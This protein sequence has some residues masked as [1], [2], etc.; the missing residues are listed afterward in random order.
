MTDAPLDFG[1]LNPVLERADP[2]DNLQRSIAY[3]SEDVQRAAAYERPT[4]A[5]N[6]LRSAG[7]ISDR[8]IMGR[9]KVAI[10]TGPQGSGKTIAS[11]KKA[12]VEAQRVKPGADGVRRYKLGVYRQKY[13][14][15]W[16]ATIPS[17][18]KVLP[19]DLAGSSWTGASPRAA[20][21]IVRFADQW[22]QVEMIADFL[23]FGDIADPEDLRGLEFTDVWLNEIDTMPEQLFIYLIGR[24]GRDPPPAVTGRLGRVMGDMNAPDVLNWTYRKFYEE[25]APGYAHYRQPG[26]MDPKAEN[27]KALGGRAYYQQQIDLNAANPWWIRRMVHA[28]PG[29]SRAT[30]L[31]YDKFDEL[32]MLSPVELKAEISLPVIVGVDGGLTPAAVYMQEMGDGQLRVIAEIALE[33]GGMGELAEA[34]LALEAR[35]FRGCEF[36]TVCDPSMKAGEDDD[37]PTYDRQRIARRSD[38]QELAHRLGRPVELAVSQE[39]TRR[40]EAVRV[41]IALNLGPRRPGYLLDPSCKGLLRGKLQTYQFRKLRGTNDLSSIAPTFDTHVADAEQYGALECGSDAARKRR[42]DTVA[43]RTRRREEARE[44]RQR[45]DPYAARRAGRR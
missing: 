39:P 15:L 6:L 13:D 21:H 33:R 42:S 40:W 31:V 9:D 14:N 7:P 27:L 24:T 2:Y 20:R 19:K 22:G 25:L 1:S 35:R 41:K 17:W 43:A 3:E 4:G 10:I 34:M 26:G 32:T 23:A 29:V 5:I 30:D 18:W 28:T 16:K 12:L 45:Y 8:Y 37:A 36:H 44:N 38:R 11:V